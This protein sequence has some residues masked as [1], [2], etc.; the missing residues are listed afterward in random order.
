MQRQTAQTSREKQGE[1]KDPE[2]G[3][4]DPAREGLRFREQGGDRDPEKE[5]RTL[6]EGGGQRKGKGRQGERDRATVA[7]P[8]K[9]DRR[10][11]RQQKIRKTP[12]RN[13]RRRRIENNGFQYAT[14]E[15]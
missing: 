1:N 12:T 13:W 9:L 14:R 10:N 4:R 11:E 3:G 6:K 8:Q 7:E 5:R 15:R 2:R